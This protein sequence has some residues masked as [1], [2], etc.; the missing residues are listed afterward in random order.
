MK[1]VELVNEQR[2]GDDCISSKQFKTQHLP[3][4]LCVDYGS[5]RPFKGCLIAAG[6]GHN[7]PFSASTK[8]SI[9]ANGKLKLS[10]LKTIDLSIPNVSGNCSE[11]QQ[12]LFL[13]S[14]KWSRTRRE[15]KAK[16]PELLGE[17]SENPIENTF[18][19]KTKTPC[20]L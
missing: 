11:N 7:Y 14:M 1:A 3:T 17:N 10:T 5:S 8:T 4:F 20:F 6:A 16:T 2:L 18:C 9:E 15:N 12:R 19:E 13:H